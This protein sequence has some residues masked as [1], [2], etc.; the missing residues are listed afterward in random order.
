MLIRVL[1]L[2]I[3]LFY[4]NQFSHYD[5]SSHLCQFMLYLRSNRQITQMR[6]VCRTHNFYVHRNYVVYTHIEPDYWNG[7]P[8]TISGGVNSHDSYVVEKL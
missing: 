6:K 7:N 2:S 4:S 3:S 5:K 8:V 1:I